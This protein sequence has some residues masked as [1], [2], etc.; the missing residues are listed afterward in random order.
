M[1]AQRTH[2]APGYGSVSAP[3]DQSVEGPV[4]RVVVGT[5]PAAEEEAGDGVEGDE[6]EESGG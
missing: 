4:E 6:A 3:L 2:R 1:R 5:G